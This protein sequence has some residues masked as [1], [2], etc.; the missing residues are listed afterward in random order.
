MSLR[1]QVTFLKHM[2]KQ[3]PGIL[4][5]RAL[6]GPARP[7][8]S[9]R[10]ELFA[11]AMRGVQFEVASRTY[12]EQREAFDALSGTVAPSLRR[13]TRDRTPL[14]GVP[15]EWFVPKSPS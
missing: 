1:N 15:G 3:T 5:S 7:S 12:A 6:N 8:W 14:G 9:F 11:R 4:Y 2:A 13:V 10:Y